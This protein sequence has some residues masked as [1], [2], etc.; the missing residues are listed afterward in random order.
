VIDWKAATAALDAGE[1]PSSS[2]EKQMLR[3]AASLA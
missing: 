1:F 3:L 2:G